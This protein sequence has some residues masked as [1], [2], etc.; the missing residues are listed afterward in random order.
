MKTED[1]K[2]IIARA[3]GGDERAFEELVT[4]YERLVYAV[5]LKLLGNEP[6]AQDAA[7]ET[8][9]KLYRYL[10][11]FRGESKF[12][13]WLY[14]LANNACIDMLRKK[15]LPTVSLSAHEDESGVPEIPDGRFSPENELEKKQLRQAV[16]RALDSLPEP[17]RQAIVL[18]E[19]A[20]QSYEEIAQ[21]LVIDIGTVKSRIFRARRRLCAILSEDGN[22]FGDGPSNKPKGGAK[23]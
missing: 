3:R 18:R 16:E 23:A 11:S 5:C 20:G 8:F 9:I 17:Y 22:F 7:Q 12:S 6:D 19:V 2:A 13:V 14:R 1:E 21:S 4:R 15:S 10:P